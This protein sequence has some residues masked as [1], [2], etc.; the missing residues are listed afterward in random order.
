MRSCCVYSIINFDST[1]IMDLPAIMKQ[2]SPLD[3]Q[4]IEYMIVRIRCQGR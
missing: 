1:G 3:I 2:I 4:E